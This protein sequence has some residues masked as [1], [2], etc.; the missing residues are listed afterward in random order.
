MTGTPAQTPVTM[1]GPLTRTEAGHLFDLIGNAIYQACQVADM[2]RD[3]DTTPGHYADVPTHEVIQ[4]L[5]DLH[6]EL[7]AVL[8]PESPAARK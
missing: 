7:F 1:F 8:C 2:L 5:S 4:D 3:G 6:S